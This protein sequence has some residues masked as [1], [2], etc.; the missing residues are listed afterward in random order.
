MG[1][2]QE[3]WW[4]EACVGVGQDALGLMSFEIIYIP[5]H[6]HLR[7]HCL[8]S[9]NMHAHNAVLFWIILPRG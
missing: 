8:S 1:L 7:Q 5:K 9:N 6:L 2:G 4:D 3:G